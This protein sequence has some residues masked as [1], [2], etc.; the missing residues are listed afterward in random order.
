MTPGV[1]TALA[2]PTREEAVAWLALEGVDL[3]ALCATAAAQTRAV[4]GDT[5]SVARNIFIPAITHCRDD[6]SYCTFKQEPPR[7]HVMS[8]DTVLALAARG[9]AAGCTEALFVTGDR[10]ETK[11]PE[12]RDTLAQYGVSSTP[13]YLHLLSTLVRDETG[14]LPHINAGVLTAQ[15]MADLKGVSGSMGLML[16]SV[17]DRLMGP[18]GPHRRAPDK[19]PARRIAMLRAGAE[20]QVPLTSGLLIG[21]GETPA[22]IIDSLF[23]LRDLAAGGQIQEIIIQNFRAKPATRMEGCGEPD[24]VVMRRVLAAARL[25]CGPDL[26]IQAPPNLTPDAYGAYLGCGITDWGGVSPITIDHVNPE[27]PWPAFDTLRTVTERAGFRL[28]ER[29]TIYPEYVRERRAYIHP[30]MAPFVD[31][32]ADGD[33]F[34]RGGVV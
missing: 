18:D 2:P 5:V 12:V 20:V 19:R 14:M 27:A 29:L 1:A 24:L 16:E 3:D 23:A 9:R 32:L 33:G 17:S 26:S 31:R 7:A 15:E 30:E 34:V 6:C 25:I 11:Y 22:E 13:E 28:R 8:P 4:H 21:I 10:P